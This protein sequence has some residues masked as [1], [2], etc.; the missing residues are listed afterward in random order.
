MPGGK[1]PGVYA[2]QSELE[3]WLNESRQDQCPDQG[4]THT[5]PEPTSIAVLPFLNLSH[6]KENEFFGDGLA[7]E[8]ITLLTRLPG[9]KVT[10]RTSSFAFRNW[11]GDIREIG[12]KLGVRTLLE[13]SVQHSRRKMR[14]SVQLINAS[15][16]F[17][18]GERST[19]GNQRTSSLCRTISQPLSHRHCISTLFQEVKPPVDAPAIPEPTGNGSRAGIT[20]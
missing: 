5:S 20:L 10:A 16:G 4:V 7:D 6:E 13:G 18:F 8:I 17:T 2:L 1:M 15:T 12:S 14:I 11:N 3:V 9:L 19:T